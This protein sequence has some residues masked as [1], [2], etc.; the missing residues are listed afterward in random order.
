M[1]IPRSNPDQAAAR[2]NGAAQAFANHQ[3]SVPRSHSPNLPLHRRVS[4]E[5]I[6]VCL[7]R[8]SRL[9]SGLRSQVSNRSGVALVLTLS[10]LVLITILVVGFATLMTTER[11]VAKS[12]YQTVV[13]R[14]IALNGR[15]LAVARLRAAL[16]SGAGTGKTW[17]VQPGKITVVQINPSTGALSVDTSVEGDLYSKSNLS[18]NNSTGTVDL[19]ESSLSGVY[20]VSGPIGGNGSA[21]V[22]NLEWINILTDGS[23]TLTGANATNSAIGRFAFWMDDESAKVNI[24]TASGMSYDIIE[25]N[26]T[27]GTAGDWTPDTDSDSYADP[28]NIAES[29]PASSGNSTWDARSDGPGQPTEVDLTALPGFTTSMAGNIAAHARQIPYLEPRGILSI[30]GMNATVYENNKFALTHYSRSPDVNFFGEPRISLMP[31]AFNSTTRR[32]NHMLLGLPNGPL[33]MLQIY[34]IPAQIG[35]FSYSAWTGNVSSSS[36][37]NGTRATISGNYPATMLSKSD[38]YFSQRIGITG[39]VTG[40]YDSTRT[41]PLYNYNSPDYALGALI[42][43]Y[44]AGRNLANGT[45]TWP[46]FPGATASASFGTKYNARQLD[47]ITLQI[48]DIIQKGTVVDSMNFAAVPSY[49]PKGWLSGEPVMGLT[50]GPLLTEML[51]AIETAPQTTP[52][53]GPKFRVKELTLEFYVPEGFGAGPIQAAQMNMMSMGDGIVVAGNTFWQQYFNTADARGQL[54]PDA[55][56]VTAGYQSWRDNLWRVVNQFGNSC[57]D[58]NGANKGNAT[59]GFNPDPDQAKAIAIQRPVIMNGTNAGKRQAGGLHSAEA[60]GSS[61]YQVYNNTA[62]VM[63]NNRGMMSRIMG[64]AAN[65][66]ANIWYPGEWKTVTIRKDTNFVDMGA[67]TFGIK[68]QGGLSFWINGRRPDITNDNARWTHWEAVPLD[69]LGG[70][71]WVDGTD[72]S[73]ATDATIVNRLSTAVLPFSNHTLVAV[74]GSAQILYYHWYVKDPL[75]NKFPADW[76]ASFSLSSPPSDY[77]PAAP[78]PDWADPS[79][80]DNR[81]LWLPPVDSSGWVRRTQRFP[82]IGMLAGLR[83]GIIPDDLSGNLISQKGVPFRTLNLS[84]SNDPS[85]LNPGTNI[86]Y[87][88]WAILDLFTV[89]GV[90]NFDQ[91]GTGQRI[92]N[93][94]SGGATSGRINP[95]TVMQPFTNITRTG[96]VEAALKGLSTNATLDPAGQGVLDWSTGTAVSPST[97]AAGV[98]SYLNSLGRPMIMAAEL[99]NVPEISNFASTINPGNG[100]I[101]PRNDLLSYSLGHFNT[102]SNVFSVWVVGQVITK[103]KT[104]I[105]YGEVETG[106]KLGSQSRVHFLVE[107]YLDLGTD[108]FAGNKD[109]P[110]SD[111]I[112]GTLDDDVDS[113]LNPMLSLPLTGNSSITGQ[114]QYKYR[115]IHSEGI[116]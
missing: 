59:V 108:K 94:T 80:A 55:N 76:N 78:P 82:S 74:T 112:P 29:K 27:G 88:D 16:E 115:I 24:N 73:T 66:F 93:F 34:P 2:R 116:D 101:R 83:T 44:L 3:S 77:T 43:R 100:T 37:G 102:Q 40:A 22:L 75:V 21:P 70:V 69:S 51:L 71:P 67:A 4:A 96:A 90:S 85:Q 91:A 106:D 10:I 109:S 25:S 30:S 33:P 111:N 60:L 13:A 46:Q 6:Q 63:S 31:V 72:I 9:G 20:P 1:K 35:N 42:S 95:N 58:L 61:I 49:L 7:R 103:S 89:P 14:A 23:S 5:S 38:A 53:E 48:L 50:R 87:P 54:A 113:A 79:K 11:S 92:T 47:S 8:S 45:V 19:N 18:G 62:G 105:K 52:G 99:A 104:N 107:R 81:A 68:M 56:G 114:P 65:P 28:I 97:V 84:P 64:A 86:S 26:A 98:E 32:T 15:D 12:S 17:A 110:G 36:A 57:V 39:N 41:V